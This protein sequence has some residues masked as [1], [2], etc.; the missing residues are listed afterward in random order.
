MSAHDGQSLILLPLRSP[1]PHSGPGGEFASWHPFLF[2]S[3]PAPSW[4]GWLSGLVLLRLVPW[5]AE[6]T[7][8]TVPPGR[9]DQGVEGG[10]SFAG[11]YFS[12]DST[13]GP[14]P[15]LLALSPWVP[16]P[17]YLFVEPGP[18]AGGVVALTGVGRGKV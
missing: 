17:V 1:T 15:K 6:G 2:P 5:E 11:V 16:G 13:L 4:L 10:G 12:P 3:F 9:G 18:Q 7:R 8:P 14:V